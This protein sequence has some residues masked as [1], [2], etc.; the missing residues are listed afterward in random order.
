MRRRPRSKYEE[1]SQCGGKTPYPSYSL[2]WQQ[3]KRSDP[4]GKHHMNAYRC[5]VCRNFHIGHSR[6]DQ[7]AKRRAREIRQ[8]LR[9][10][11]LADFV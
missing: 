10:Q 1:L 3:A 9:L 2:A 5:S 6:R 8:H 7:T 4:R 11:D